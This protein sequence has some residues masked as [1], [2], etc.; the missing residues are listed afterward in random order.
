MQQRHARVARQRARC[1]LREPDRTPLTSRVQ[2]SG[3]D[4][5][6]PVVVAELAA[7][8]VAL[9]QHVVA[10]RGLLDVGDGNSAIAV[11][12]TTTVPETSVAAS[13]TA[14]SVSQH[15]RMLNDA[16]QAPPLPSIVDNA[17]TLMLVR[18]CETIL[19]LCRYGAGFC[20]SRCFA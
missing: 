4:R 14:A 5:K 11:A 8:L 9:R 6:R 18:Q 13:A 2:I 19:K 12:A 20:I 15:P 7:R 16:E 10:L 1:T 17:L 3:F